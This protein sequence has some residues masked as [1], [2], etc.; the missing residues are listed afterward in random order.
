M[1]MMLRASNVAI[2]RDWK[3]K[4]VGGSDVEEECGS[5]VCAGDSMEGQQSERVR[6]R[7]QV[8]CSTVVQRRDGEMGWE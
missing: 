2:G 7:L 5:V 3:R 4:G 1:M 8:N 6:W